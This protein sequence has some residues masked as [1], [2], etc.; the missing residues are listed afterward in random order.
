MKIWLMQHGECLYAT[1]KRLID[2]PFSSLL[3]ICV[4]GVALSLPAAGYVLLENLQGLSGQVTSEPQISLFLALNAGKEE[5]A[6]IET[7]LRQHPEVRGFR[8]VPREAALE[9]L[10]QTAGLADVVGSLSQNPLPDAFVI[11]AKNNSPD[12]LERLR[13]EML[14]WPKAEYVQLDP[15]WAKRLAA[16]L[17]LGRL[18][19]LLLATL[20]SFALVA[21]TFNTIRLQILTQRDEI[22]IGKLFG[23]TNGFIRRPFLYFGALQGLAGGGAAWIIIAVSLTLLNTGITE[24][25]QVYASSF[26]LKH[27]TA[28]DALS[29][30]LFSSWLGWLGAWLSVNRQLSQIEPN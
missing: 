5:I 16:L 20:L 12:V 21:V 4:F 1:L 2:A 26:R 18:A 14:K 9:Q 27:L 28:S 22:E 24:L 10:K 23:A 13:G 25:A 8:F 19:V 3:N 15:E 29:L 11:H 6:Q 30:L 17:K 7:K